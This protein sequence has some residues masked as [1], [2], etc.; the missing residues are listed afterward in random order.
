MISSSDKDLSAS[1]FAV[2]VKVLPEMLEAMME[3]FLGMDFPETAVCSYEDVEAHT[4]TVSVLCDSEAEQTAA[5][6]RIEKSIPVW[7]EMLGDSSLSLSTRLIRREDWSESWKKYF[8]PFRASHRLVIKPSWEAFEAGEGDILLEIDPGM[9]FGTGSHGTTKGCLQYLDEIE[10]EKGPGLSCIDAGCG[11]GILSMAARRLG[12]GKL[13]GFDYDPQ[14][15]A[16]SRENLLAAGIT[17]VELLCADVHTWRPDSPA[18][19]VVVNILA[20]ILQEAAKNI[21][22]MC[23]PGGILVLSGIL[24]EQY[25]A[26]RDCFIKLGCREENRR[27]IDVWTSG[28]FV[29]P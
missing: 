27:T 25:D 20:H 15:V 28:R 26:V 22:A 3:L 13:V 14:A 17:D 11:S 5:L 12:Y 1:I 6:S 19:V 23:R 18:D 10:A 2:D 4:A 9:C 24:Q 16:T 29:T 21:L 7:K 8:H